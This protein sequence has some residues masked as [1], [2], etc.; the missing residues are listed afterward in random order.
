RGAIE[1]IRS[2]TRAAARPIEARPGDQYEAR[3][4][5]STWPTSSGSPNV[6][7][8]DATHNTGSGTG[9]WPA[10]TS[11]QTETQARRNEVPSGTE[12]DVRLERALSSGTTQVE[13]RFTATTMADLYQGDNL[14]IPAGST[15]RGVVSS[16]TRATRTE[17]KGAMT[18]AF[19]QIS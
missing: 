15:L 4:G 13:D 8:P 2:E 1:S 14:L 19:D 3:Q 16:V 12:L 5:S 18:V 10:G 9:N 6:G 7:N 11:G 17:R